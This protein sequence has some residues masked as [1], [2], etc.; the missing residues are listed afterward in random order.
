[1]TAFCDR[2]GLDESRRADVRPVL[3]HEEPYRVVDLDDVE[4]E[5][6]VFRKMRLALG[7]TGFGVN[8]IA[9]PPGAPGREHDEAT[10]GQEEVYVVLAGSGALRVDGEDVPLR[11]GRWVRVAPTAT[12][13]P[14]AGDDGLT[15]IAIGSAPG[16]PY[17]PRP[18]L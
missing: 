18:H 17:A 7:V 4:P 12:R 10:C 5:M 9:L 1:V 8:H 2:R 14:V 3:L 16:R 13:L 6:G 15:F 11:P